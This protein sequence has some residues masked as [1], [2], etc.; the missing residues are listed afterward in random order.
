MSNTLGATIATGKAVAKDFSIDVRTL[1][2]G[3]YF[4]HLQSGNAKTV[5]RFIKE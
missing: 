2:S 4:I 1:P 5:K 3:I